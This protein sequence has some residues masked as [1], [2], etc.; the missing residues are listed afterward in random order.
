M[1]VGHHLE[2]K[3]EDSDSSLTKN[4]GVKYCKLYVHL[5]VLFESGVVSYGEAD[6]LV[7]VNRSEAQFYGVPNAKAA[8]IL[9]DGQSFAT[10]CSYRDFSAVLPTEVPEQIIIKLFA[11]TM[12][13]KF[14]VEVQ[15]TTSRF[16]C[17]DHRSQVH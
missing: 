1:Y 6:G 12:R 7:A 8:K 9:R 4:I 17:L 11:I 16:H 10:P 13:F 14:G 2:R 3:I 5:L 15:F